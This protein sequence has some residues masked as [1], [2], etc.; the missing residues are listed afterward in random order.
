LLLLL[1]GGLALVFILAV[2][3]FVAWFTLGTR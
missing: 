3:L 2:G 1:L